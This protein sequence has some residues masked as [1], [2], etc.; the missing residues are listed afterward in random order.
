ALLQADDD[1]AN[2]LQRIFLP[3]IVVGENRQ[4]AQAAGDFSHDGAFGTVF[5]A[6]TPEQRDDA[7]FGIQLAGRLNEA[8]ERVIRVCVIHNDKK[9]LADGDL[10]ESTRDAGE[11][12]DSGF[13][14]FIRKAK[15]LRCANCGKD[16]VDVD[17]AKERTCDLQL[18]V[19]RVRSESETRKVQLKFSRVN[20]GGIFDA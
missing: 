9:R 10:L 4:V 3:R 1:I 8:F 17:S 20:V 7:A 5:A 16:V 13:N 18:S 19:R 6:A 12:A 11:I 14:R 15:G 2:D